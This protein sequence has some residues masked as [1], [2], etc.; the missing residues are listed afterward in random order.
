MSL[1]STTIENKDYHRGEKFIDYLSSTSIKRYLVSPL[2]FKYCQEHPEATEISH[3]ASNAGSVYHDL[4]ASI[5]NR[6]DFSEFEE[7]WGVFDAPINPKTEQPFGVSTKAYSEAYEAFKAESGKDN[8]CS[9]DELRVAKEMV[10]ML[11]ERNP[12]LS[13]DVK[14]L[15]EIG[16]AEVSFFQEYDGMKFKYRTDLITSNKIVDWKSTTEDDLTPDNIARLIIKFKY[17]IS[18]AFYQFLEHKRTGIWKEFYWVVQAKTPPYDFLIVDSSKWTYKILGSHV[19]PMVGG[20]IVE[21]LIRIH[22]EC[23]QKNFWPGKAAFVMPDEFGHRI[24]SPEVPGY[25]Q[26]L[27]MNF[28]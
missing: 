12:Y 15:L 24:T 11:T 8:L 23:T 10:E 5:A 9:G 26:G 7:N 21:E 1:V 27:F 19:Q 2:W 20:M 14:K 22:K 13:K 25:A 28:M 6:G 3:E 18:A 4:L 16:K 17:H